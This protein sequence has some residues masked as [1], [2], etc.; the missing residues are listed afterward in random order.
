MVAAY[1]VSA[2]E[3]IIGRRIVKRIA[4]VILANLM[5]GENVVP[6]LLQEE[7]TAEKLAAALT[8]L[9]ADSPDRRRQLAAFSRLDA[10]MQIGSRSPAATAADVVIEMGGAAKG[11]EHWG[12][13]TAV[14]PMTSSI[15]S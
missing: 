2:V 3:S 10:I 1:K 14:A 4:S 5:L 6:E 12:G 9:L 11:R 13:G 8:P 15:T 7:C